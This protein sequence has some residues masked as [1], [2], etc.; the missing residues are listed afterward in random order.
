MEL[1]DG[2]AKGEMNQMIDSL[3]PLFWFFWFGPLGNFLATFCTFLLFLVTHGCDRLI[4]LR[5]PAGA[6]VGVLRK[7]RATARRHR[8]GRAP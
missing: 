3:S 5:R 6:V 1:Q 8:G 4:A 7:W 2:R